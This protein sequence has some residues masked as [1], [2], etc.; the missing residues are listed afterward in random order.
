[1]PDRHLTALER[2]ILR[3]IVHLTDDLGW[4]PTYREIG[5]AVGI[6]PSTVHSHL[7]ELE[8]RGYVRRRPGASRALTVVQR[9]G[10][11]T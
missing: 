7:V 10:L 11:P 9:D 3:V 6:V 2:D 4:P 8:R 1:M 5:D